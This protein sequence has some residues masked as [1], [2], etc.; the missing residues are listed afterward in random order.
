MKNNILVN[1]FCREIDGKK[2]ALVIFNNL[3]EFYPDES[4]FLLE[5]LS[6]PEKDCTK[7][8]IA[9]DPIFSISVLNNKLSL[10]GVDCICEEIINH[11]N[12]SKFDID[13]NN[14]NIEGDGVLTNCLRMIDSIF[15]ISLKNVKSDIS[16][17]FFGYYGYDSLFYFEEVKKRID[18]DSKISTILLTAYR[19]VIEL[20]FSTKKTNL[21]I[22]ECLLFPEFHYQHIL[23]CISL[24]TPLPKPPQKCPKSDVKPSISKDIYQQWYDKAKSHINKGDIYQI[25]LGH[26]IQIKSEISPFDVYLRL[27]EKNPSPYMYFF[28]TSEDIYVIGA[29][30]ELFASLTSSKQL[31]MRPIAGT[32]RNSSD[33][34]IRESNRIKLINDD[35]EK[36]EHLMLVDLCRNDIAI[37]TTPGSL[38]VDQLMVT[39]DY[40]HVIHI[41]SNV[42]GILRQDKDKHDVMAATFPAGTMTGTPKIRAIEIIEDTEI[43]RR[44]IYAGC[45]GY[46]GINDTI[47]TALCIRTATYEDGIYNIRASGGIVEDSTP[48]GEWLETINKLG[49]TYLAITDKELINEDFIN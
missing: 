30:P 49:S 11:P 37:C 28:K 29:S 48:Y 12:M 4:I 26:E 35:K 19:G 38:E 42:K 46:W 17:G 5:S 7:S 2:D 25:Q 31:T 47:L 22:N 14:I 43:S 44:N 39:E 24:E 36:A 32:V 1:S 15:E 20:D 10:S 16:F 41:V 27:R 13:G 18:S 21:I 6:G 34:N 8:V 45:V 23:D 3:R 40:S 9:F 33:P